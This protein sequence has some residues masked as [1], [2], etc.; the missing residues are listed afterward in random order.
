[1][2]QSVGRSFEEKKEE[3]GENR[4]LPVFHVSAG[5]YP[6]GGQGGQL[7]PHKNHGERFHDISNPAVAL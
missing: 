3:D 4:S 6:A 1:M 7:P 5:P 2:N